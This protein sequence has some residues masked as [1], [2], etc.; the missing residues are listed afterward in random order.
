[1]HTPLAL[2]CHRHPSASLFVHP[3][4][5]YSDHRDIYVKMEGKFLIEWE[6]FMNS[7]I[8]QNILSQNGTLN[9]QLGTR[10]TRNSRVPELN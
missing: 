7:K 6:Y 8:D 2:G 9:S 3:Q 1:M 5:L 4:D 10:G